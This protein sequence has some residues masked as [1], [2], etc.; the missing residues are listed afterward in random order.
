MS[1]QHSSRRQTPYPSSSSSREARPARSHRGVPPTSSRPATADVTPPPPMPTLSNDA[2][3]QEYLQVVDRASVNNNNPSTQSQY[4][5]NNTPA[6]IGPPLLYYMAVPIPI[7]SHS[8]APT[9]DP[10]PLD[11]TLEMT[12]GLLGQY[13]PH[14]VILSNGQPEQ[15]VLWPQP[16]SI[17]PQQL[18]LPYVPPVEAPSPNTA[19]SPQPSPSARAPRAQSR[20]QTPEPV[21]VRIVARSKAPSVPPARSPSDVVLVYDGTDVLR[22]TSGARYVP[23]AASPAARGSPAPAASGSSS[24]GSKAGSSSAGKEK[25]S[26]TSMYAPDAFKRTGAPQDPTARLAVTLP[27]QV[28]FLNLAN[29]DLPTDFWHRNGHYDRHMLSPRVSGR[30]IVKAIDFRA[31]RN[32]GPGV[33]LL[34]AINYRD[35][36]GAGQ[37]PFNPKTVKSRAARL[38]REWPSYSSADEKYHNF[39]TYTI[40][41]EANQEAGTEIREPAYDYGLL[42]YAIALQYWLYFLGK[43]G[44]QGEPGTAHPHWR[45]AAKGERGGYDCVEMSQV[46]LVRLYTPDELTWYPEFCVVRPTKATH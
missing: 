15:N 44:R 20:K 13:A 42:A 16:I 45:I 4:P 40:K 17:N 21:K 39:A 32:Y 43:Q 27:M 38:V 30:R 37:A 26:S 12:Q 31:V 41:S 11:L 8:S 3:Y 46:R 29:Q 5:N 36:Y 18:Q 28:A 35:V 33:A 9:G 25:E 6:D 7:S 14:G 2:Y 23:E 19:R 22:H 1:H 34:E 24:T 10:V